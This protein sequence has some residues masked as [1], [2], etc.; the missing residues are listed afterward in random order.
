MGMRMTGG[1]QLLTLELLAEEGQ[2]PALFIR[3]QQGEDLRLLPLRMIEHG[4]LEVSDGA[5]ELF[6]G[7]VECL[8]A[9]QQLLGFGLL[10]QPGLGDR[11]TTGFVAQR[12]IDDGLFAHLMTDQLIGKFPEQLSPQLRIGVT[13]LGKALFD[14]LVILGQ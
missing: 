5:T 1:G 13:Q 2:V 12:R 8:E 14:G 11:L 10:A 3:R 9:R 4:R 7:R 6:G